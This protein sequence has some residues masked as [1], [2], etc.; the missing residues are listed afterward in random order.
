ME[1][2][3]FI[4]VTAINAFYS[5]ACKIASE[6]IE[7]FQ[8]C[9]KLNTLSNRMKDEYETFK[10]YTNFKYAVKE[11]HEIE[12]GCEDGVELARLAKTILLELCETR[13]ILSIKEVVP[14]WCSNEGKWGWTAIY[15]NEKEA[16]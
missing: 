10:C 12:L 14:Q 4:Q 2:S 15:I 3:K 8:E 16:T 6:D 13:D 11:R 1:R 7:D 9:L 5:L